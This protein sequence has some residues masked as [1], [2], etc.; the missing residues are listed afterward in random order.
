MG[1]IGRQAVAAGSIIRLYAGNC[2]LASVSCALLCYAELS[3]LS[4]QGVTVNTAGC[5]CRYTEGFK[6]NFQDHLK[7]VLATICKVRCLHISVPVF[8]CRL[9]VSSLYN[10]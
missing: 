8:S 10:P 4:R 3:H 2:Q 1:L 6:P 9:C 7:P 5:Y